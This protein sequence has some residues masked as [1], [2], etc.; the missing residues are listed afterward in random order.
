MARAFV[1]VG[2]GYRRTKILVPPERLAWPPRAEVAPLACPEA[3]GSP[4]TV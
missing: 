3:A 2:A 4:A 1:V